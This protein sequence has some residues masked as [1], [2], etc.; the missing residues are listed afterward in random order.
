MKTKVQSSMSLAIP[1]YGLSLSTVA[2]VSG[3]SSD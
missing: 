3:Y 1:S 2:E